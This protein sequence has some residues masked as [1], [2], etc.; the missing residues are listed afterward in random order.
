MTKLIECLSLGAAVAALWL[1]LLLER[2]FR[3]NDAVKFHV[4]F[5]PVYAVLAFGF[6]SFA[7]I[8]Y[9]VITFNEC[10]HAYHELKQQIVDAK[11]ELKALGFDAESDA[12]KQPT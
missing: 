10:T 8:V 11:R 5:A 9:R 2:P 4:W 12:E 7:V 3:L 1:S 6:A